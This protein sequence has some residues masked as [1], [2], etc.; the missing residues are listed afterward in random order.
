MGVPLP[1][2]F[3]NTFLWNFRPSALPSDPPAIGPLAH[4]ERTTLEYLL[5]GKSQWTRVG[6]KKKQ[7]RQIIDA[8][9]KEGVGGVKREWRSLDNWPFFRPRL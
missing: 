6:K 7:R 1:D 2:T 9:T 3:I 4:V 8:N 5:L